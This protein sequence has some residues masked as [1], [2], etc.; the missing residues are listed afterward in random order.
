M[1]SISGC[2]QRPP[3]S[4]VQRLSQVTGIKM[5]NLLKNS[6]VWQ[7]VAGFALGAIGLVAAH[8][9]AATADTAPTHVVQR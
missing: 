4:S 6:F 9:S 5:V 3:R 7:F 2:N 8:P 1:I